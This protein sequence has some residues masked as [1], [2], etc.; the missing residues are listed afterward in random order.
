LL[1]LSLTISIF[2]H[3]NKLDAVDGVGPDGLINNSTILESDKGSTTIDDH[4]C[5]RYNKK[6]T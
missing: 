1:I 3:W 6:K 5:I 4:P 2:G